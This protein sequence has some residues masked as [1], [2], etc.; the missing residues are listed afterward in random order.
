MKSLSNAKFIPLP[1]TLHTFENPDKHWGFM[2]VKCEGNFC[3]LF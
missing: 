1:F 2:P 3:Q